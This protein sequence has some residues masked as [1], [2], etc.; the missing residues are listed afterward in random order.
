MLFSPLTRADFIGVVMRIEHAILKSL[1]YDEEYTRKVLPFLKS[2][3]FTE[4][5]EQIIYDE[6]SDFVIK[7]NNNPSYEAILIQL[8]EKNLTEDSYDKTVGILSDICTNKDEPF[9]SKWLLTK[10]ETFCQ[11]Q[12]IYL[13]VVESISIL[14]GKNKNLDKGAIP[15]ILEAALQIS[16]NNNIGHDYIDD[17]SERFESYNLKEDKIPF[18]LEYLNKITNG[19]LSRGTLTLLAAGT[20]VGKSLV[21]THLASHYLSVGKNVLYITLEMS[22]IEISKRIDANLLNT[23]INQLDQLTKLEF[24]KKIERL[25]TQTVGKLIVKQFPTA[26]ASVL[27]FQHLINE[28]RLKKSFV[29]DIIFVDY[30]NICSSSRLKMGSSVN[31]YTFIKSVAEEIRGLAIT[32]DVPIIS[33]TQFNRGGGNNSDPNIEDIS[34]S[35][36]IA[37]TSDLL[38]GLIRTEELDNLNQILFKQIKNRFNDLNINKRFLVGIDRPKMRLYDIEMSAQ[39][40]IMDSGIDSMVK[41][42]EKNNRSKFDGFK[43]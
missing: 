37:M 35:H 12:A 30:L 5:H 14:D 26:S 33:S 40:G 19:G 16:F 17:F 21:K 18:D 4:K 6:V 25:K 38:I 43:V 20:G 11:D 3:Y 23:P 41:S 29:P 39:S 10:T 2:E 22:E 34:E 28:L 1:I 7:Y 13:G 24:F 9:D 36:G 15:K 42:I 31:S 8:S 27:H 32:N